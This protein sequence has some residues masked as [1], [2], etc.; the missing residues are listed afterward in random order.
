MQKF[1]I[2]DLGNGFGTFLKIQ[3][4]TLL[5][6]NSLINIGD[7]YIV[8]QFGI[9]E[10]TFLSESHFD[11]KVQVSNTDYSNMINLKIFSGSKHY[12]PINFLPTKSQIKF[13]RSN[14]C[15]INIDDCM[16]SRIH[17]S[18]EYKE[19]FGWIIRDGYLSKKGQD[20]ENKF[21]TNGTW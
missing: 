13:G 17:C 21:S 12:D 18:I 1:Y 6:N 4:E 7:S 3:N 2:K 8:C 9:N 14:I 5:K 16:L 15:E 11:N 19:N 10:D 20:Y